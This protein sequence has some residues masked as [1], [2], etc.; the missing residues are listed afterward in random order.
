MKEIELTQGKV[1]LVDDD[2]FER[3]NQIRWYANKHANTFYAVGYIK[4]NK[5]AISVLMHWLVMGGKGIDHIDHNGLNNQKSNLRFCTV[6]ENG[7]NQQKQKNRSSIYKGV[8]FNKLSK[9]WGAYININRK[10][11]YLG[12]F[13]DEIQA[14]KA[15]NQKAIE[16]FRE[17]ANLNNLNQ[18]YENN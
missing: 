17:F 2:D 13:T 9:K 14:A 15:Y 7:M 8:Y 1:A 12:S 11:I 4:V 16:L 18:I 5:K 3:L 6:S 10:N